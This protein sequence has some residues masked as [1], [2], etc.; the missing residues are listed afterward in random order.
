MKKLFVLTLFALLFSI[1]ATA[2]TNLFKG[3]TS[4][5]QEQVFLSHCENRTDMEIRE[6]GDFTF[7]MTEIEGR[8]YLITAFYNDDN[9][10]KGIEFSSMDRYEWMYYDPNILSNALELYS[11][12]EVKY[13]EPV[14]DSWLDWT[15]IPDGKERVVLKFEKNDIDAIIGISEYSDEYFVNLYIIDDKFADVVVPDSGG[16]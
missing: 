14:F 5:M 13:G 4:G 12:L 10:L 7:V 15:D 8:N 2:Q 3:I 16:F 1:T 9:E 6:S 11:L